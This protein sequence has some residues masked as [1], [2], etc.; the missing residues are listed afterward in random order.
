MTLVLQQLDNQIVKC[1]D[2]IKV[3]D[4]DYNVEIY[5]PEID[6][7]RGKYSFNIM[8]RSTR[9]AKMSAEHDLQNL[10]IDIFFHYDMEADDDYKTAWGLFMTKANDVLVAIFNKQN[11]MI[12][13]STVVVD[14]DFDNSLIEQ[15]RM[16]SLTYKCEYK[17]FAS[18]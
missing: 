15:E 6:I 2:A 1:V 9:T 13:I 18:R 5:T 11:F 16:I 4:Q 12:G 14:I 8:P 7:I 10:L 3:L 17:M